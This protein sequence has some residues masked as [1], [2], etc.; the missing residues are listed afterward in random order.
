MTLNL[1]QGGT[2]GT[3]QGPQQLSVE[4]DSVLHCVTAMSQAKG[5][6]LNLI[7]RHCGSA[8]VPICRE[9]LKG[10]IPDGQKRYV[11]QVIHRNV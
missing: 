4:C 3:L 2:P 9:H 7:V 5:R 8:L 6:E 10:K 1:R 11:Q